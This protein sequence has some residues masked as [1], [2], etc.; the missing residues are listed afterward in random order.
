MSAFGE[1][2]PDERRAAASA[3]ATL[4]GIIA[5]HTVL[6]T[7][8]DA[9]FLARLP[10]SQLPWV[11]LAMAGAAV[12]IAQVPVRRLGALLGPSSLSAS[13]GL[14]AGVTAVFWALPGLR[15]DWGLRA[16]YVWTGLVGTLAALQFWLAL[17]EIFTITQAKRVY[18][19]VG[20]GSLLGAVLGAVLPLFAAR[21][22]H[23]RRLEPRHADLAAVLTL[24]GAHVVCLEG[25]EFL[26]GEPEDPARGRV[27]PQ[28]VLRTRLVDEDAGAGV[29]DHLLEVP[30][31]GEHRHHLTFAEFSSSPP[32]R[33]HAGE[34]TQ[35]RNCLPAA[36][37]IPIPRR[38]P[39][40]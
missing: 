16:L 22:V 36:R 32:P 24:L 7:A 39:R 11:Y 1:I 9:L 19:L 38:V 18:R 3:F 40:P 30:T 20:T 4:F 12:A 5:S 21:P 2:R 28:D 8:R 35:V 33:C 14:M 23:H 17:G 26:Q 25:F 15:S 31:R 6:E 34:D 13:L 10:P 27:G 37:E 29:Q